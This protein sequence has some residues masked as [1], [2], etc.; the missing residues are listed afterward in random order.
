LASERLTLLNKRYDKAFSNRE[1][2]VFQDSGKLFSNE[3]TKLKKI[4]A[5]SR[6]NIG[7]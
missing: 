6:A 7:S 3:F 5:K 4:V 1:K 2:E